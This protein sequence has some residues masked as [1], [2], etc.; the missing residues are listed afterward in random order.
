MDEIKNNKMLWVLLAVTIF[1]VGAI[2]VGKVVID[3]AADKVID[4]LQKVYGPRGGSPYGPGIDPDKVPPEALR[5][6]KQ[7]FEMRQKTTDDKT[8]GGEMMDKI[9]ASDVW[10]DEWEKGRGFSP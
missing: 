8:H 9:K 10:R 1:N 7:H 2:F 6:N 4:R 5:A 3:K